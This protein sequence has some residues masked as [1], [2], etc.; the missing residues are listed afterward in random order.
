MRLMCSAADGNREVRVNRS[1]S[2][3]R[4]EF[5]LLIGE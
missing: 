4:S 3:G 2:M 1:E 5:V